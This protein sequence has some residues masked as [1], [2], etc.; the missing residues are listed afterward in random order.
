MIIK[1]VR[2][3]ATCD[4]NL[5]NEEDVFDGTYLVEKGT[6]PENIPEH[7]LA[8]MG[9]HL[10]E[11]IDDEIAV[12]PA[13]PAQVAVLAGATAV[14]NEVYDED[15]LSDLT[16]ADLRVI[17]EDEFNVSSDKLNKAGLVEAI[18]WAQSNAAN[19]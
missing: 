8:Q 6:T 18:L 3:K 12:V 14:Q 9:E 1:P 16:V 10:W 19:D 2:T 17:L 5:W 4:I 11:Y 13:S 15:E 7:V